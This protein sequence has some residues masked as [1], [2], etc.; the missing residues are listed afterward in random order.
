MQPSSIEQFLQS[1]Q[2]G[3]TLYGVLFTFALVSG[4]V[5]RQFWRYDKELITENIERLRDLLEGFRR[6]H[7]EPILNTEL[8]RTTREAY[9][10]ALNS[11]LAD[12]YPKTRGEAGEFKYERVSDEK[13]EQIIAEA[14]LKDRLSDL[15][16]ETTKGRSVEA[17]F[18]S[19]SGKALLDDLD[20]MYEQKSTV[21]RHYAVARQAC[22]RTCYASLF[23]SVLMLLGILQLLGRWPNV[24]LFFWLLLLIQAATYTIFSF[25]R[26]E[27]HRHA[28][29]HMWEEFQLYG[30][31]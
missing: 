14:A 11:L 31:V 12:L 23:F 4:A 9:E 13:V 16:A 5:S 3:V 1:I 7:I 18:S 25:I 2:P 26:L 30:K 27:S 21:A 20:H 29:L 10:L 28:L 8:D 22:G 24:I 19:A 6:R 17:F 15:K